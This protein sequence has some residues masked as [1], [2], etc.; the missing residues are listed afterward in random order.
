MGLASLFSKWIVC[1]ECR[2]Q[3]AVKQWGAI[4]CS[5]P[6]CVKYDSQ[7]VPPA[8]VLKTQNLKKDSFQGNFTPE[9]EII[10]IDYRNYRGEQNTYQGD[11]STVVA[12]G[13]RISIKLLP[14]GRRVSFHKKFLG[15]LSELERYVDLKK[16]EP[17]KEPQIVKYRNFKGDELSI[18]AN[19]STLSLKGEVLTFRALPSEH[20]FTL[21]KEGVLNLSEIKGYCSNIQP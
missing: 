10:R 11:S 14:T 16:A 21:K 6:G 3:G 4:K 17:A 5:H 2:H 7:L 1:P 15:N 8:E 18:T 19:R 20:K 12:A 9:A 13:N